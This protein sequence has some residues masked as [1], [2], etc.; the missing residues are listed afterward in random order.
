MANDPKHFYVTLFS[1]ASQELFPENTK[2]SFTIELPQPID[3]GPNDTWEVGLC[4]FTYP[5]KFRGT[6]SPNMIIGD[7]NALIYCNLIRPQ[8]FAHRLIRCLRTVIILSLPGEPYFQHIYYVPVEKRY[9]KNIRME[10]RDSA[11]ELI[12]FKTDKVP[13]KFV[14]H[15]RRVPTW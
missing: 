11:G 7:T 6:I 13:L 10:V 2:S 4:E 12:N 8:F 1:N 15:F 14:L 5:P 9:I 3:L